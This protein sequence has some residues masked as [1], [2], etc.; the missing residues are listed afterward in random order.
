MATVTRTST[1]TVRFYRLSGDQCLE[2][3]KANIILD[4]ARAELLGGV[5]INKMTKYPPHNF[6]MF[7][8]NKNLHR[9][10]PEPWFFAVETAVKLG[11]FWYPEPDFAVIRGPDDLYQRRLAGAAD[12]GFLIEASDS[13]YAIDRG[14]KWRRYG[15]ARV[16]IYWIVNLQLRR[17]EVYSNPA[18]WGRS[19][20]Y[21]QATM[22]GEGDSVPVILDGQEYGRIDV[23]DILP[24]V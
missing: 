14:K 2:T 5:L 12:L 1:D 16:P 7:R 10:L 9:L 6:A 22:F 17:I 8:L 23:S 18:G 13:S 4:T 24:S 3:V 21:R 19:A 20:S 15:A 11:R